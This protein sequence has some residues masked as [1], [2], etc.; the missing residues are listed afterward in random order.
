[1][2]NITGANAK[3]WDRTQEIFGVFWRRG[4][5]RRE[6]A[7]P[8]LIY[9]NEAEA[10]A[11]L[12]AQIDHPLVHDSATNVVAGSVRKGRTIKGSDQTEHLRT[13]YERGK[14]F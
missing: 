1:M 13:V 11:A 5:E 9:S 8:I 7:A 2:A 4:N 3:G 6:S 12:N 14:R 10:V